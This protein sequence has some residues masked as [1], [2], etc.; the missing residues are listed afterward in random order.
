MRARIG[1][2]CLFR[3]TVLERVRVLCCMFGVLALTVEIEV[4]LRDSRKDEEQDY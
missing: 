2:C 3:A 1:L 4:C